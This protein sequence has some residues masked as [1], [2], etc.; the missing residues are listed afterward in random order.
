M[1]FVEYVK[2]SFDSVKADYLLRLKEDV[3]GKWDTDVCSVEDLQK[4]YEAGQRDMRAMIFAS[5]M[6]STDS[7]WNAC[8]E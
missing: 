7:T 5:S 1:S 4:A 3:E 6:S 2:K 8:C